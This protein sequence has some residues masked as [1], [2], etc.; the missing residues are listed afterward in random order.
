MPQQNRQ[1]DPST[2]GFIEAVLQVMIGLAALV[3][4]IGAL[5]FPAAFFGLLG[6]GMLAVVLFLVARHAGRILRRTENYARTL[7]WLMISQLVLW[8]GMAVLL[9][10]G[11]VHPVGFVIGVSVLPVSIVMTLAWY[12]WK[13][14]RLTL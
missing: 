13:K 1:W 12:A 7:A 5:I 4:A 9:V 6:G 2:P 3:I 11:R 8:I 10:V 14:S